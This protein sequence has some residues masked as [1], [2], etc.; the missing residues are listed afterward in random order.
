MGAANNNVNPRR[1]LH[2][3][4]QIP[5]TPVTDKEQA[6]DQ[7]NNKRVDRRRV[8]LA[9]VKGKARSLMAKLSPPSAGFPS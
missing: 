6:N 2:K 9:E 3:H 7:S 4:V 8:N 5:V 1:H